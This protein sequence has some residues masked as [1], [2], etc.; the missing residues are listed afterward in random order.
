MERWS[1]DPDEHVRRLASEGSRPRLPW[2]FRLENLV[3]YPTPAAAILENLRADPSLYVRQSVANH[4]NDISKNHPEWL[5]ARLETWDLAH[6]H[7]QWIAK[8]GARTLIKAGHQPTLRFF[9][10]T[11]KPAVKLSVFRLALTRLKI[12]QVLEFSFT[13]TSTARK[14]QQLAVDYVMHYV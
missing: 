5:L 6:P 11:G 12:E 4:L 14:P 7:T 8:H 9:N 1:L 2:S 3:A 10:F 13:L